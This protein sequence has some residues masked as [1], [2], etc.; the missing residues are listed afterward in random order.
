MQGVPKNPTK[1]L[2]AGQACK[3]MTHH[4][5][6]HLAFVR[7]NQNWQIPQWCNLHTFSRMT[8]S[9]VGQCGLGEPILGGMHGPPCPGL[10]QTFSLLSFSLPV[11][12]DDSSPFNAVIPHILTHKLSKPSVNPT[13]CNW[14]VDFLIGSSQFVRNGKTTLARIVTNSGIPHR[15]EVSPILHTLYTQDCCCLP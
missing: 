1:L 13:F 6:D 4:F 8:G 9:E 14:L 12:V 7:E 5:A 3:L 10:H 15:C 11:F 2:P